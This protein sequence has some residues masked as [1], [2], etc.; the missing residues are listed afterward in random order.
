MDYR[1]EITFPR[2]IFFPACGGFTVCC[3]KR[4]LI[5]LAIPF[6]PSG[7][8]APGVCLPVYLHIL[9]RYANQYPDPGVSG[10]LAEMRRR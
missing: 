1:L 9:R 2:E 6:R 7:S 10:D 5:E 4:A 8:Q 3:S